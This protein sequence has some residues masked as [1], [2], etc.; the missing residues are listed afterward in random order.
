M[1]GIATT[2]YDYLDIASQIVG[3]N[4]IETLSQ[5]KEV[6]QKL[7]ANESIHMHQYGKEK[8]NCGACSYCLLRA[9]RAIRAIH[10]LGYR[11]TITPK[12]DNA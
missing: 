8:D 9:G 1:S 10:D 12:G 2:G 4:E 11:I 5:I 6:A 7:H 3:D